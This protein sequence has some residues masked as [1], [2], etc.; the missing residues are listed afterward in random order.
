MS[1]LGDLQ[2]LEDLARA[3]AGFARAAPLEELA[4]GE[5]VMVEVA[6]GVF[7]SPPRIP[8]PRAG[9]GL[10]ELERTVRARFAEL[11]RSVRAARTRQL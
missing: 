2:R 1:L 6:P 4:S 11:E 10:L 3:A 9:V 8:V 5:I 7:A